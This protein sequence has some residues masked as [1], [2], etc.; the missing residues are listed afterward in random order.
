MLTKK[1]KPKEFQLVRSLVILFIGLFLASCGDNNGLGDG[2]FTD[3]PPTR[4]SK[5]Q[6]HS[7]LGLSSYSELQ[8]IFLM[9]QSDQFLKC[10]RVSKHKTDNRFDIDNREAGDDAFV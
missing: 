9:V 6:T 8:R 1:F 5:A 10:Q 4:L 2:S 7:L 3:E